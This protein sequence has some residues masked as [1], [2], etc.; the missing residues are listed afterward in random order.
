MT[1]LVRKKIFPSAYPDDV[2]DIIKHLSI[3][4][5]KGIA[6]MGSMSLRSQQY[7]GDYDLLDVAEGHYKSNDL[8]ID[9][10]VR[11]FQQIVKHFLHRKDCYI[12]DIKSGEVPEWKIVPDT[13]KEYKFAQSVKKLKELYDKS[14]IS[15][16]EYED[17]KALLKRTPSTSSFIMM[18]RSIKFHIIRWTPKEVLG[19]A[20]KLPDGRTYWLK[21]ALASPSL[22]KIDIIAF[23]QNSR[24]TDFSCIYILQNDGRV[25][26]KIDTERIEDGIEDDIA[27]YSNEG[28]WFKV[29]KRLFSLAR[30]TKDNIRLEKLNDI[31][32]S[33]LGRLYSIVSDANTI[34]YLLENET[35][36]PIDKIRYE[37]D[38]F[39][40]RISNVYTIKS[41]VRKEPYILERIMA[42]KELP[43]TPDGRK[44]LQ[45][46]MEKLIEF[47]EGVLN[48]KAKQE[49]ED[50][51][52]I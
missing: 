15:K 9:A 39:R 42:I 11:K 18:Q 5:M 3:S 25:L 17:S 27:Y 22:T 31:L 1:D 28:N 44:R 16:Q 41:I 36:I 48:K 29:A 4:D 47:F 51:K 34:L 6:V 10:Y 20:K 49:L 50:F 2:L 23:V 8:A 13:F 26:N 40:Q 35:E 14:I 21:D 52:L 33:D 12:G 19:G 24:F 30:I 7:A 43:N 37:L 32:N 45:E 38:Q 46:Q